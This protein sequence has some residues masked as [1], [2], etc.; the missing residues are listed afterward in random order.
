[1]TTAGRAREGWT[2]LA[3]ALLAA[4][5][6]LTTLQNDFVSWDDD[7]NFLAHTAWRG[8][9]WDQ[10]TWMWSTFHL[11]HYVPLS[12]MTLGLDFVLWGMDPRGYHLT[13]VVLHAANAAVLFLVGRR[14]LTMA[15]QASSGDTA[16]TLGAAFA[17][18]WFAQHPLRVE[19]VAWIT[20]RRDVLSGLLYSTTVLLYLTA[21]SGDKMHRGRYVASIAVFAAA[22]LSKATAMTVPA[23]L[24]LLNLFPLRRLP[25]TQFAPEPARRLAIEIAPFALLSIASMALSIVALSPGAQL[26][27]AGKVAV[28]AYG[29]GFYLWKSLVPTGLSPY[30]PLPG[31]LR[32]FAPMFVAAYAVAIAIAALAWKVRRS[33]PGVTAAIVAFVVIVLPMLGVVQNGPQVA[34]D[35]YTY[36]AAPALA[37]LVGGAFTLGWRRRRVIVGIA[38]ALLL[39][40]LSLATWRQNGHWRD[41]FTLWSRVLEI[42]DDAAIGHNAMGNLLMQQGRMS[43][44][45]T[46]YERAVALDPSLAAAHDNL[47]VALARLGRPSEA[48]AHFERAASDNDEAAEAN[49]NWGVALLAL[50]DV[51]GAIERFSISVAADS[52]NANAETNFGSALARAGALDEAAIHLERA[53]IIN[54]RHAQAHANWGAVLARLGRW[55]AAAEKLGIALAL[56]PSDADARANLDRVRQELQR[57][58]V[59][60]GSAARAPTGRVP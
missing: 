27:L 52:L 28:S 37:I 18:L 6:F 40:A 30:Y 46:H 15:M 10:L 55:N 42:S 39:T 50:G 21:V 60:A 32:P 36:H 4:V 45:L 16:V 12:W 11:G 38:G 34:A 24:L 9:G 29:L 3:V 14:I 47:G 49:N 43:Q 22:L 23:V 48:I 19:S 53:T 20:E 41:S 51:R 58:S 25:L 13:S 54:P 1:M 7:K 31:D 8:L 33:A 35:R 59:A 57:D 2:A 26:G 44:A 5:P 56:D 17:A